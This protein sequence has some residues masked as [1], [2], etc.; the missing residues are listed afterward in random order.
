MHIHYDI[1]WLKHLAGLKCL[2]TN[3]CA[4]R[5]LLM[6]SQDSQSIFRCLSTLAQS[7]WQVHSLVLQAKAGITDD[8]IEVLTNTSA[9]LSKGRRKRPMPA[10]LATPESIGT[11][12]LLSS[13][14]LHKTAEAS[15]AIYLFHNCHCVD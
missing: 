9:E 1:C 5:W 4:K 6:H 8:I 12:G 14:P 15:L 2:A 13:H 3:C 11:Y 7:I 10:G